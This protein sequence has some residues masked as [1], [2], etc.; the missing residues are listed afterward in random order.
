M[1]RNIK[2]S[3]KGRGKL[4]AAGLLLVV[5][6]IVV[7]IYSLF[8]NYNTGKIVI[9]AP[10]SLGSYEFNRSEL[11]EKELDIAW[12]LY[13]QLTTRKAAIPIDE[14]DIIIEVY[15]SWYELFKSTRDYLL[16]MSASDL[17]DNENAQRIV[18]LSVNVLNNGLRPHL[19]KWQGKYRKWYDDALKEKSNKGLSPQEIQ[20]KYPEYNELM[21]DIK[22]VN[23]ELVK[24][25]EELK[26][27][28][29]EKTPGAS[30]RIATK[31]AKLWD[32]LK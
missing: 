13:V 2:G 28:S 14:D 11:S 23:Q 9:S 22:T 29:H 18:D 26:K 1:R 31:L 5:S 30:A 24:Y 8:A 3:G 7:L 27:F 20:K 10:F 4:F 12:R 21:D 17:E 32:K 25:A 6:G 19:T 15:N 16:G